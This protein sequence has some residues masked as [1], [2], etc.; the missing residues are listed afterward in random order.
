M[1]LA[2]PEGQRSPPA[3]PATRAGRPF[4]AGSGGSPLGIRCRTALL[5]PTRIEHRPP[6]PAIQA[7]L[8]AKRLPRPKRD[9]KRLL[10]RITRLLAAAEKRI[11]E[12]QKTRVAPPVDLLDR[13]LGRN[14]TRRHTQHDAPPRQNV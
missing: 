1:S 14:R 11:T 10:H 12:P 13:Q 3:T 4:A 5:L 6:Q 7:S 9:R 8:A 2:A